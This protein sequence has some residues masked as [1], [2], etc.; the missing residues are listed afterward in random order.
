MFVTAR[1]ARQ[2]LASFVALIALVTPVFAEPPRAEPKAES[3][4]TSVENVVY[5]VLTI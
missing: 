5:E 2:T 1:I 3:K 4:Y